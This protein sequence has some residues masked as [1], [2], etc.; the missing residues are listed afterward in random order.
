MAV[1][2]GE[3]R[4][5]QRQRHKERQ[6]T[7]SQRIESMV[8]CNTVS[9]QWSKGRATLAGAN[10]LCCLARNFTFTIWHVRQNADL[11]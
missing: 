5:N 3:Q 4:V 6:T 9:D 1:K 10:V 8:E 2:G 7:A 11:D